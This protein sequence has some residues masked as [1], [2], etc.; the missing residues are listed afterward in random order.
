MIN[1]AE[2]E[3][4]L[5]PA[6]KVRWIALVN[7]FKQMQ[8]ATVAFSGGVDSGLLCAAAYRALGER[9]LAVTISSPVESLGDVDAARAL[10]SQV[11]FPLRVV[12]YDDLKNPKFIENPPDRCYYCKLERF[13]LMQELTQREGYAC[14][15]EGSNADDLT[16]YRPGRRAVSETS[17]RSPLMELEMGKAEIR[18]LSQALGLLVW[19]RPSAPCLATRFPYGATISYEGLRQV[20]DGEK[21]LHALGFSSLRVRHHGSV[22]RLEVAPAEIERLVALRQQ[23]ND[24]FKGLGFT[25]V[26]VDL[27][28]YRS[29]SLNEGLK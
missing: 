13:Y 28:G 2:L 19:N 15:V 7:L 20:S 5:D 27:G 24:Y 12:E 22:A 10:A 17:T 21:Y 14:M 26:A 9:M 3:A 1:F 25:Y 11:G 18:A 23:I 16:D 29:G 8:S 4:G 6:L